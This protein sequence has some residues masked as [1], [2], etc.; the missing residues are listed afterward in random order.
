MK[1]AQLSF[2]VECGGVGR[3]VGKKLAE[4]GFDVI[5][6]YR[7]ISQDEAE[8]RWCPGDLSSGI[9]GRS[10]A[11]SVMEV[12]VEKLMKTVLAEHETV[13]ACVHAAVDPILRKNVLEM[14]RTELEE[15]F[16]TGVF[17]GI[18]PL[19]GGCDDNEGTRRRSHR[20]NSFP[21]HLS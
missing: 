21:G 5:A 2:R 9:I 1:G 3:V 16:G 4:D 18:R 14:T 12:A 20:R 11:I 17:R 13:H 15:Q 7:T 8:C 10:S 19:E 6:L